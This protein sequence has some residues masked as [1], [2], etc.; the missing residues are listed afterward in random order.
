MITRQV[1]AKL[2]K[3]GFADWKPEKG[4]VPP[5]GLPVYNISPDALSTETISYEWKALPDSRVQ[6]LCDEELVYLNIG[7]FRLKERSSVVGGLR[8]APDYYEDEA[9]AHTLGNAMLPT[10]AELLPKPV[11][12]LAD[13]PKSSPRGKNGSTST[14]PPFPSAPPLPRASM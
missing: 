1:K 4:W 3:P 9:G 12:W 7:G 11:Q 10:M 2:G 8:L 13:R 14:P 6:A 5:E